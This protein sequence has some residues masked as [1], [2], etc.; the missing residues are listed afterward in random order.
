[1]VSQFLRVLLISLPA[2]ATSQAPPNGHVSVSFS[3]S[4]S[5]AEAH[6]N[7]AKVQF[8]TDLPITNTTMI[9]DVGSGN[10]T[11]NANSNPKK[12]GGRKL[13]G[14][15]PVYN[16]EGQPLS[17]LRYD[18]YDE[19][20][21][22]VATTTENFTLGTYPLNQNE[23]DSLA[24]D[25]V[26]SCKNHSVTPTYA[27]GGWGG[28]RYF[29]ALT[30][31]SENRTAFADSTISFAKKYGFEGIDFDW[32]YA[33][34][35]GIGCNTVNDADVQNQQLLFKEVKSKWPEGKLS[36]AQSIAGIRD[37]NYGKLPASDVSLMA[38]VV[39]E[40][41]IM[42]YDVHGSFTKT[43]GPNAP[44]RATCADPE[45]QLS[46]ETAIEIY[47]KQGFKP[48]QLSLGIPGYAKSW[49]LAKPELT[50]RIVGNYTSYYYQNYTGIPAGGRYD[51]QPGL[52][53]CGQKTGYGGSWLVNELVTA[54]FLNEDE[55]SGGKGYTRYYDECS[56]EPFL[57]S[58][59]TLIT[60]DDTASTVAKVEYANSKNLG[61]VFFFDTMGP[62]DK[63]VKAARTALSN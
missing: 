30:A 60:Y 27:V 38:Q 11:H 31:T 3:S 42:A 2:L 7:S 49:T 13:A 63:T 53:V 4:S 32:E 14:Y 28:S 37:A 8:S 46:V 52:D 34:I 39:D 57:A 19:I 15:Y 48:E 16:A 50:P 54:G 20:I 36:T 44:I 58:E 22:F 17:E 21:F 24:F 5:S 61:G 25:F 41:R 59:T 1:M 40:V 56:G 12:T 26:K 6:S 51:D 23:W 10:S 43:T 18:L 55:N 47:L 62:R 9:P 45:N 29:S 33:S 35:Q